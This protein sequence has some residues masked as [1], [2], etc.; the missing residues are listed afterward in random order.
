MKIAF[1]TNN[2]ET[3]SRHY[4]K[5]RY[6]EVLTIE[7]GEITACEKRLRPGALTAA[8]VGRPLSEEATGHGRRAARV[9]ADCEVLVAGGMGHGASENLRHAGV[10]PIL[11]DERSI[12]EATR[13]YLEGDLPSLEDL[14]HDGPG[15]NGS[16]IERRGVP[17]ANDHWDARE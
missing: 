11:T 3:I 4:G 5:A 1:V 10:E 15:R 7:G 2:F 14:L 16:V 8:A 9:V 17:P 13:R 6:F 12:E